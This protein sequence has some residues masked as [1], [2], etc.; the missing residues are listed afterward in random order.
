MD[1]P[2]DTT[3]SKPLD[4][5]T[6]H[7]LCKELELDISLFGLRI[8][9][10]V[11]F[12]IEVEGPLL[13]N[14]GDVAGKLLGKLNTALAPLSPIF[15]IIEM[16]MVLVEV[17]EAVSTLDPFKIIAA[18]GKFKI[19]IDK[20]TKLIPQLSVPRSIKSALSVIIVALVGLRG[21]ILA[22]AA[23]QTKLSIKKQRALALGD[24]DLEA[25]IGCAQANLDFMLNV[26]RGNAEPL[27]R[28]LNTLSIFCKLAKLPE[29][30]TL[31]FD[32]ESEAADLIAPIDDLIVAL[33][34]VRD[35]IPV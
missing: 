11:N 18:L 19:K 8:E 29:L 12:S 13:P 10:P 7:D 34:A 22:I 1:L 9:M 15:D 27:N 16:A 33:K 26:S 32:A 14:P 30:P 6:I 17:L 4:E 31:S 21:E 35:A 24:L 23:Q 5:L 2:V 3:F 20:L 28:L 25:S